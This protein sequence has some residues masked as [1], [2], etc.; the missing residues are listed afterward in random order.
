MAE[1][2]CIDERGWMERRRRERKKDR[3]PRRNKRLEKVLGIEGAVG[4][5]SN[6]EHGK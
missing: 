4:E 3:R 6:S 5:K 2:S 1:W